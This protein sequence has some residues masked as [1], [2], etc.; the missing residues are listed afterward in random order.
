MTTLQPHEYFEGLN[1]SVMLRSMEGIISFWNRSAEELYGW[2][3]EDAVGRVSHDLLQ[4][5]FPRPLEEI[6]SEL[7]QKSRWE[8]KLVHTTRD[9]TRVVVES[10]WI[11]ELDGPVVEI[12]TPSI[13]REIG[14]ESRTDTD[15][16]ETGRQEPVLVSKWM[17]AY[18]LLP[19]IA[20]LVLAGGALLCVVAVLTYGF[21]GQ[22][23]I[24]AV[25]KDQSLGIGNWLMKGRAI[26]PLED[27]YQA[28]NR[29]LLLMTFRVVT[30]LLVLVALVISFREPIGALL[31]YCSFLFCSFMLFG[32]FELFPSLIGPFHLD[33][34][35]Y[36]DWKSCCIPDDTLA[37]RYRPFFT[38][39]SSFKGYMYSTVYGVE[40]PS[41]T[42]EL[43]ADKNGFIHNN[44][45]RD[46]PDIAIIGDSFVAD[47]LNEADTFGRRLEKISGLTVG[48]L[49]VPGYGPLQYL[50][51]LKRY[52]IQQKPRYALF[53]FYS[54]NDIQDISEY[55][56]WKE[57][58]G[59]YYYAGVLSQPFLGRY[60]VALKD[61][62]HFLG[63]V[64]D[65]IF[66]MML[67]KH[68][69]HNP[70]RV[71]PDIAVI[72]LGHRDYEM[73]IP[74]E[75]KIRSSSELLASEEGQALRKTLAG[76]KEICVENGIVP[77]VMYIPTVTTIYAKH[78]N[79]QSGAHW[80]QLR[81]E[82]IARKR[83]TE[84][85]VAVL[86]RSLDIRLI[87]LT[88][89]FESAAAEG[90]LLYYRFDTHWNS[91]GKQVAAAYV[92]EVLK[93]QVMLDNRPSMTKTGEKT[94]AR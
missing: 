24:K 66:S 44:G 61:G 12:N 65:T 76:F 84:N 36:Y 20:G 78:S 23:L 14:R 30:F 75:N 73:L 22:D 54:G 53:V 81:D 46:F 26:T 35:M 40:V 3:K 17:K 4:T 41:L 58:K 91:E 49:G 52:G 5:Q 74:A 70:E 7:L 63:G 68:P 33:K 11:L 32:L 93:S 82:T 69:Y 39:T 90:K 38:S 43:A 62:A 6:E 2:T 19:K 29:L 86:T 1:D 16:V 60:V 56:R 83:N 59:K 87:N 67:V 85:A 94:S 21:F 42:V 71:H 27:Y 34:I 79:H 13:D 25:Y 88:P 47:G 48:N 50:E 92:A 15:S 89:V 8:G 45:T 28:A 10:R 37:Y 18:D 77:I 9:G 80:L 51:V 31:T 57:G 72:T 55:L 64:A